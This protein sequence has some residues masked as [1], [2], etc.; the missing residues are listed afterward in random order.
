[1][2]QPTKTIT[3]PVP[4]ALHTITGI[5]LA[6]ITITAFWIH[7]ELPAG[8][9]Y[10]GT[11]MGVC[12]LAGSTALTY[13]LWCGQQCTRSATLDVKEA[14]EETERL[15]AEREK[16]FLEATREVLCA[17]SVLAEEVT[18]NRGAI[19]EVTDAVDSVTAAISE[20]LGAVTALQDCYLAEGKLLLLPDET[21]RDHSLRA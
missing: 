19:K 6:L 4:A 8:H 13:W 10:K 5:L 2:T 20:V 9:P 7:F 16:R 11:A 15:A 18:D 14:V 12:F 1:M 21:P 17:V 3:I